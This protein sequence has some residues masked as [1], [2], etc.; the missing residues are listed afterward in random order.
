MPISTF[1]VVRFKS[2]LG[3]VSMVVFAQMGSVSV[4]SHSRDLTARIRKRSF[5]SKRAKLGQKAY[6]WT[7]A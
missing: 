6:S 2:V 4:T 5:L 7:G 3:L 1:Q